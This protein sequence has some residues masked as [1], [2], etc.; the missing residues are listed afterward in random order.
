MIG[1]PAA[2]VEYQLG[3]APGRGSWVFGVRIEPSKVVYRGCSV[4]FASGQ[5]YNPGGA[6]E[7]VTW[8]EIPQKDWRFS[9]P[10]A[11]FVSTRASFRRD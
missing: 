7:F 8:Y 10:T 1:K 5:V 9:C 4:P 6:P 3:L 2:Q 11:S